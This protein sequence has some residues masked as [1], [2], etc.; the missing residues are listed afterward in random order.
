MVMSDPLGDPPPHARLHSPPDDQ[1]LID[2][3]AVNLLDD[4]IEPTDDSPTVISKA[5][6]HPPTKT[7]ENFSGSLR[8]RRLAHFELIEPIGVGGM[9]AV[10]RARDMQL[11]RLVALKILPPEMASDLENVRRFHQE[12]R[13]AA[14]L[15]L[16]LI[17]I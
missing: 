8:G 14:K 11:D 5:P 6:P 7:D 10:L 1:P 17:H 13:S 15:D 16:S 4:S 3:E 12:A 9:A 2:D